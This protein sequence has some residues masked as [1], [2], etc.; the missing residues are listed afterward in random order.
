M[1]GRIR[2]FAA[3]GLAAALAATACTPSVN[4]L[5]VTV[6]AY[7]SAV[8]LNDVQRILDLSAPYQ[9]ALRE[10]PPERA[11]EI[12]REFR[13]RIEAAYMLWESARATGQLALDPLGIAVIR[14]I[15]LGKEGAA[16]LPLAVRFEEGN[17]RGIVTTRALSNYKSIRWNSIPTGGRIY[18]M[19]FPFGK[20][21]NFAT[22]FDDP[23]AFELLD[24][25]D[26]EWTLTRFA[27]L[28]TPAA[29]GDWFV[30]TVDPMEG[31]ATSW[32]P[33]GNATP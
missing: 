26:L 7:I 13:G 24:T 22:G 16:A 25:V 9:R 4:T 14:S 3:A 29:P 20:V 21:I 28:R 11:E 27:G 15:G 31:T 33:P 10:S 5:Q 17:T 18:L 12:A 23:S 6:D 2:R 8:S 1:S 19:G 32:R 30:E